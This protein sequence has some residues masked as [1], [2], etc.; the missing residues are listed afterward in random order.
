MRRSG[1]GALLLALS[2]LTAGAA[3]TGCA[4]KEAPPVVRE[5][6][7]GRVEVKKDGEVLGFVHITPGAPGRLERKGSSAAAKE[8]E[9]RWA[10]DKCSDSVAVESERRTKKGSHELMAK[11][12]PAT[13]AEYGES[14]RWYLISKGYEARMLEADSAGPASSGAAPAPS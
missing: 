11:I 7:P 6:K 13:S 1:L 9:E 4:E 12:V 2:S 14:V 8:L 10:R 5:A 3:L